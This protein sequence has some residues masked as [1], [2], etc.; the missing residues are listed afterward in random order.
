MSYVGSEEPRS[1]LQGIFQGK[2]SLLAVHLCSKH[3]GILAF[4]HRSEA[5]A[6][7]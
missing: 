6:V 3:Q 7:I 1:L 5:I 4:S 2:R